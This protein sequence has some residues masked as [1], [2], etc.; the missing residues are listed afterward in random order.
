MAQAG[1]AQAGMAQA[2]MARG[3]V[4]PEAHVV[5]LALM[6]GRFEA[7]IRRG[8][9]VGGMV[10]KLRLYEAAVQRARPPGKSQSTELS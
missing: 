10:E 2:G 1:M 5:H 6:S 9:E 4:G 8:S 7:G 3:A